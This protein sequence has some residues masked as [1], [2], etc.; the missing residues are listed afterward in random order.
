MSS[1]TV[2]DIALPAD[3][4]P[5]DEIRA[6]H[7]V[8][9]RELLDFFGHAD[10]MNSA[11]A[12]TL[13]YRAQDIA[14]KWWLAAHSPDGTIVAAAPVTLPRLDNTGLAEFEFTV[15]PDADRAEAIR[16]LWAEL[17]PRLRAAGRREAHLWQIHRP[18]APDHPSA[19]VPA[20]REGAIAADWASE[21]L[22][23]LGF[24]LEQVERHSDLDV[25]AHQDS[26]A[27]LATD[28]ATHATGYDVVTWL[29]ATPEEHLEPMA[30]LR[31]RMSVDV[32]MGA[33]NYEEEEWDAERIRTIDRRAAER[34]ELRLVSAARHLATGQLAAYTEL[35]LPDDK[36][37][38]AWQNDTLVHGD[39][40]GRRLG[41]LV[42]TANLVELL[43]RRPTTARVH[44]WNA[45]ENQWML[46][47]NVALGFAP[48]S[49]AGAWSIKLS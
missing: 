32:P 15:D 48:A 25:A 8:E 38:V 41:M 26:W 27:A 42:K 16:S 24:T 23:E 6:V 7:R 35:S 22:T 43:R 11:E 18:V 21:V 1:Y 9:Q 37:Q 34:G 47:I 46:A 36:P 20:T 5:T 33:L 3:A 14:D 19:V 45:D 44:T 12:M 17:A 2:S 39:H 31:R 28:A 49:A 40:R 30:L 10:L 4:T 13:N 29:G